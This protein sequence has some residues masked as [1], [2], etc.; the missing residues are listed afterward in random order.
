MLVE[1]KNIPGS[2][3]SI[4]FFMDGDQMLNHVVKLYK[5]LE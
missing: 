3:K 1:N 2:P 5:E 4:K